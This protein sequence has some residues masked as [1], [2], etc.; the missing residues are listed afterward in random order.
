MSNINQAIVQALRETRNAES[1]IGAIKRIREVTG[2][3]LG[4]AKFVYEYATGRKTGA[5]EPLQHELVLLATILRAM[6]EE[7][8]VEAGQNSLDREVYLIQQIVNLLHDSSGTR[9]RRVLQYILSR[10]ADRP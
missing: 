3:G 4:E 6:N 1:P 10:V 2:L 7:A 8:L 5:G 9:A